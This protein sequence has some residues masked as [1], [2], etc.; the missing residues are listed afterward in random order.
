MRGALACDPVELEQAIESL[1]RGGLVV[2]PAA[3]DDDRV[4]I[5]PPGVA[6]VE[7]WQRGIVSLFA[8]WPPER[9]DVD[10]VTS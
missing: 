3:P 9:V 1:L 2:R 6:R 4:A 7:A 8:G 10:D 5:T